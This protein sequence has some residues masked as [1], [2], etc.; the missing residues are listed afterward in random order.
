MADLAGFLANITTG[1]TSVMGVIGDV[2]ETF[3]EPP[4]V[5]IPICGCVGLAYK[6]GM[7]IMNKIRNSA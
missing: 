6:V 7:R 5:L 2:A 4:L 3:M 1:A